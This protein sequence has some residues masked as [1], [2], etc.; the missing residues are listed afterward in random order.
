MSPTSAFLYFFMVECH[1]H[2]LSSTSAWLGVSNICFPPLLH[3]WVSATSAFLYFF[4]VE[5]QQHLLSSTLLLHG[6]CQQHLFSSTSSWLSVT[7]ISFPLL[8]RGWVSATSAFLYFFMVECH[9]HLLSSTSSWLSVSNICF[10][11]LLHD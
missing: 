7:N 8:L 9:Q 10:P 1:Q 2:L 5:C 11:L 6:W 3:G 4:M